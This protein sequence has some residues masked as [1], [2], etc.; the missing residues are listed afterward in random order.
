MRIDGMEYGI[1]LSQTVA[2]QYKFQNLTAN[3][4]VSP[5]GRG[6]W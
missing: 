6:W 4:V 2:F 1:E 5:S 3:L